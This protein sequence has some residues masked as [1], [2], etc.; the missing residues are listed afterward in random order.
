MDE[1]IKKLKRV[2]VDS[3]YGKKKHFNAAE[4]IQKYHYW[5]GIPMII[6]NILT[7]S[8]L[9]YVLTDKVDSWLKYV[10]LVLS[11][12]AAI[13]SGFQTFFKF[14]KKIEAHNRIGNR[15]LETMKKAERVLAY[16]ADDQLKKREL[17]SCLEEIS[18]EMVEINKEA[19]GYPPSKSDYELAKRGIEAGEETYKTTEL[20]D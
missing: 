1:T 20:D 13:L 18:L 6:I 16:Y 4:R 10:P 17:I 12:I 9:F 15:Y 11:L 3:L 14:Q 5:I 7:G 8:I 19:E 2:R